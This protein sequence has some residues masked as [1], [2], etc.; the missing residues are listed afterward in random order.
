MSADICYDI[1]ERRK[2]SDRIYPLI[3]GKREEKR[4][5]Y[6]FEKKPHGVFE[7]KPEYG[8][9]IYREPKG[10][11]DVLLFSSPDGFRTVMDTAD[12]LSVQG[13]TARIVVVNDP[14]LFESQ[15]AEYKDSVFSKGIPANVCIAMGPEEEKAFSVYSCHVA[16]PE[17]KP[18]ELAKLALN[19][20]RG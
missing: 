12:I 9:Y 20:M 3:F 16:P 6:E 5:M 8:A 7:A 14:V 19:S 11:P 13:Y 1:R 18:T 4:L 17:T 2:D 10:E 15:S